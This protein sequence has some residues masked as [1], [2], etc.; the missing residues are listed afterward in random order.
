[1]SEIVVYHDDGGGITQRSLAFWRAT[2]KP[3]WK[4]LHVVSTRAGDF[5]TEVVCIDTNSNRIVVL[6]SGFCCGYRGEGPNGLFRLLES[7]GR[8][9]AAIRKQIFE[10]NYVVFRF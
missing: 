4:V 1:M 2:K 5:N 7:L 8:P 10:N 6:L 9:S 3:D